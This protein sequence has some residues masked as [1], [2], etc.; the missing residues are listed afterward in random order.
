MLSGD[1]ALLA[2]LAAS[3][4]LAATLLPGGSEAVGL[5][6]AAAESAILGLRLDAGLSRAEAEAEPT[7]PHLA[8]ALEVGILEPFEATSGPRVRLTI[9]G[10]LLSNE[11]FARLV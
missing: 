11:L 5:A 8:W 6:D 10:R 7:G 9:E 1:L 4:F 3:A 2:G